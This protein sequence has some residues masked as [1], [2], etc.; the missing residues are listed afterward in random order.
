MEFDRSVFAAGSRAAIPLLFGVA[1]FGLITGVA[2]VASGIS[3]LAAVS[4]SLVVFA[5]ASF[6][7]L[8]ENAQLPALARLLAG[9]VAI[10]A[11][12]RFRLT[13]LSIAAGMIALHLLAAGNAA[14]AEA[15]RRVI[16][17]EGVTEYRLDNGLRVLTVPDPGADTVTVHVTYLVGS[18]QEGYGEKGMAHLLEHLMFKGTPGHR[19][20]KREFAEHGARWNGTT[21]YDRTNYFETMP[22]G[23]A[24]LEWAL[25]MEADRM[26]DSF[27]AKAD[28]DSEMT[29]VRN[30]F[31]MGENDPG[32]V[33]FQRT[34]QMAYAWH[35]YG[36]PIIG[37][38]S[39]IE[40]V[41]IARLQAF[42]RTWYQPDDA[43]LI[44]GGRFDPA[45]ALELVQKTFG[46]IPRPVRV[47][48]SLYTEEPA[49]DGP[50]SVTLRRAGEAPIVTALYRI[51]AGSDP[52][53]PALDVLVS[54]L[55]NT[56]SGRLHRALVLKGLANYTW[57]S[58]RALHDPGFASFGAGLPK[59][60][61]VD[62]ARDALLAELEGFARHPVRAEEVRRAKTEL[63]ND[64]DKAERD[65]RALPRALSEFA[66]IGDWRLFYLYRDRLR[67]VTVADVQ[68]V[69]LAYLKPANRVLG[70]FLPTKHPDRAQIPPPPD[71]EQALAGYHGGEALAAGEAFDPT[72]ANI[73]TRVIRK[74]LANGIRVALLPKKTRGQTVV[75]RL[76]LH[77]GDE[78]SMTGRTTA[79]SLAGS[80]LSRGTRKHG[81][82]ELSDAFDRL[83]ASVALGGDGA[84]L[85][86]PAAGLADALRLVAEALQEPAFPPDEFEAL[87]R[88]QL[89]DAE[90]QRSDPGAIASLQLAR[91][92][93]P[94][95]KGHPYYTDT[96]DEDVEQLSAATLSDAEACYREL[97]GASGADFGAVGEFDPDAL[98]RE[99]EQ[100]YGSWKNPRP[101]ERVAA[102][103]YDQPALEGE[104]RTP[105][106][107]N[108]VLRA[109]LNIPMR[110]DDPD[111]PALVLANYLL[112]GSLSARI[113]HRVRET[114][115]LSYSVF[116]TFA[117]GAFYPVA[118]FRVHAIF[119]PGNRARVERA[120][121]EELSRAVRGGFRA[122]EVRNGARAL[123]EA[124]RLARRSDRALAEQLT[125]HLYRQ[126]S[127]AWDARLE[128]RIS[129]LS[130]KEVN[131]ALRRH[132]DPERL[133]VMSAGD[134][135]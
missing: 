97:F 99:L 100:L 64:F 25:G 27:I 107:A 34:L 47:L 29:V 125:D 20:L 67:A 32:A 56:P 127:F 92:L 66:A 70:V 54:V 13:Y 93:S 120:V 118:A 82:A 35:N 85:E 69:A 16:E 81:R 131:A 103:Y 26:V 86:V 130:A 134:F 52:D 53:Y 77:W 102:R 62:A 61:S 41:P 28:L 65:T 59:D 88:A 21:A 123:I 95:P 98:A 71:L 1:P 115:G 14:A 49:Q 112:G 124:R 2:M 78:Q 89:T 8:P 90:E 74:T 76:W 110:D 51:P 114:E 105:D 83:D 30:E 91:H 42:Y 68:R 133:S 15:P 12:W 113:P 36:H 18:R 40:N 126:R 17:I 23:E 104:F 22:A 48:P 19:D 80:M 121:R 46:P 111:Y 87:R 58:E 101:Y 44:V 79:C 132:I 116:T 129:A 33:L 63:L 135:K 75:A 3:P 37:A 5:G 109:G 43:L 50:R 60:A 122:A 24:N 6:L 106:K 10:V 96:I 94:Y 31:E 55:G 11:A 39:D 128:Q 119:A 117:A 4:M 38:R 45:H 84:R 7:V 73:E 72:P 57:G 108:A 9:A